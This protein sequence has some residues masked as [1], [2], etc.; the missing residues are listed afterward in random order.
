MTIPTQTTGVLEDIDRSMEKIVDYAIGDRLSGI[1]RTEGLSLDER[2][3]A[4]AEFAAFNFMPGLGEDRSPW[5][6]VFGPVFIGTKGVSSR[7]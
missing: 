3:G 2:K 7:I 5:E 6:T 1:H 4:W